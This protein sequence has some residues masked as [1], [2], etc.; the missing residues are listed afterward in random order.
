MRAVAISSACGELEVIK[1]RSN[2]SGEVF[3]K[4]VIPSSSPR[5]SK[6]SS[7]PVVTPAAKEVD[8]IETDVAGCGELLAAVTPFQKILRLNRD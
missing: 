5:S 3:V 1:A 8:T 6:L 4:T 7:R 2:W